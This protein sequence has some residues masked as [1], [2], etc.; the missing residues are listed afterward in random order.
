MDKPPPITPP[1]LRWP[2]KWETETP[3]KDKGTDEK[4]PV[5][6]EDLPPGAFFI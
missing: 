6:A 4:K 5:R 3:A 2:F 1:P